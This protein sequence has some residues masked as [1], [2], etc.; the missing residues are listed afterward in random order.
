MCQLNYQVYQVSIPSIPRKPNSDISHLGSVHLYEKM[1]LEM[2]AHFLKVTET[3]PSLKQALLRNLLTS[4]LT[5][6]GPVTDSRTNRKMVKK[7]D[8]LRS[9]YFFF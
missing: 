6:H 1:H 5:K 3:G 7:K 2:T 9:V 4:P 8:L